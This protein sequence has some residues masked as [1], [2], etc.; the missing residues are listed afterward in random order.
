MDHAQ[1]DRRTVLGGAIGAAGAALIGGG[2]ATPALAAQK[3]IGVG[4]LAAQNFDT[5]MAKVLARSQRIVIPSYRFGMVLRSGISATGDA[6]NVQM[7]AAADL[8]GVD[9]AMLRRIAH[10]MFADFVG[11]IRATGRTVVSSDEFM[12]GKAVQK[13]TVTQDPFVKKPFADARTIAVVTPE[14]QP[15]INLH[16]DAPLSDQSPFA[17]GNWRAVNALSV[18][19]KALVMLPRI[20]F[21]FAAL[22]GSG[23]KVYGGN[24]SV[25]IQPGMYLVPVLT[26]FGFYHAKIALAGE[27]GHLRLEDRVA[28]GQAGEMIKSGSFNNRDEV[29]RWNSYVASNAWWTDPGGA[30][31]GRPTRAYDFSN[32]QYRVDP[33]LLEQVCLDGAMATHRIFAAAL[34]ANPV[35]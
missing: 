25:G 18:E 28:L 23:H 27:G 15:L 9:A 12:T 16:L 14:Y 26:S 30:V 10:A 13:L 35:K 7:E 29:D 3:M 19:T 31:P 2:A 21:D 34:T 6:G 4:A 32:Y 1:W 22:T 11:Q 8:V 20:V 17:L 24:A 5:A 33:A